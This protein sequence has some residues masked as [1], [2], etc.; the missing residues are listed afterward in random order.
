MG[1]G[2]HGS[3]YELSGD[4]ACVWLSGPHLRRF[5]RLTESLLS[6]A[7][8]PSGPRQFHLLDVRTFARLARRID[9]NQRMTAQCA[10]NPAKAALLRRS[11]TTTPPA[12]P[13]RPP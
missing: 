5:D 10:H 6:S 8:A 11:D 9:Y 13:I 1:P 4:C 12:P 7:R 3:P 2:N